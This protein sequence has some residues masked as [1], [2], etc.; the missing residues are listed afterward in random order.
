MHLFVCLLVCISDPSVTRQGIKHLHWKVA[1]AL[2]PKVSPSPGFLFKHPGDVAPVLVLFSR[3][4]DQRVAPAVSV[5]QVGSPT[6]ALEKRMLPL[7]TPSI[8]ALWRESPW[9]YHTL[10]SQQ[11]FLAESDAREIW[12]KEKS[13]W[14]FFKHDFFSCLLCTNIEQ[15]FFLCLFVF[16]LLWL[17]CIVLKIV[18][19]RFFVPLNEKAAWNCEQMAEHTHFLF[20][21]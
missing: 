20:I 18:S 5:S 9:G 12:A 2:L 16:C 6:P 19:Q 11:V 8:W 3:N 21:L 4:W 17:L 15:V 7:S 1:L 14:R 10:S 13:F